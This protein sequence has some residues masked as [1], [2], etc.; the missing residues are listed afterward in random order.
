MSHL[1]YLAADPETCAQFAAPIAAACARAGLDVVLTQAP[2]DPVAVDY[3]VYAPDGPLADFTPF[4]RCRAV[5]SLWAGVERIVANPTLTQPLAR[6]VETGLTE[7]M[8]EYV[9][10]HVLRHHLGLDA[11]ITRSAP[12]WRPELLPPLARE[13][14][15]AVLGLGA[16]GGACAQALAGLGFQVSG[17][18]RSP[19]SLAG[20]A[21][22]HGPEG[23]RA[24]LEGAEIVVALLPSTP[25]TRGLLDAER[26]GWMRRGA[27]LINP[28][29]GTL[30]DEAALLAALEAG[31]LAHATLDVF[32][33]EPLPPGHPFW[34]HPAITITP[35][36]AA[37]T[38]PESAATVIAENI[39]RV[40]AG[41]PLLH[42]VGR[43]RGY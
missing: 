17:W 27:V 20:V 4:S 24:V 9:L 33:T 39:A 31:H 13:R 42:A 30:V 34:A 23:L 41:A 38:R 18:A 19:R 14:A 7:G 26:L 5:L 12:L 6:M 2:E 22:A 25:E 43:A 11:H 35:H 28:G 3:I 21:C 1:V 16:L 8:V 29:R 32:Q 40:E 36:I 15:V 37:A 10:G